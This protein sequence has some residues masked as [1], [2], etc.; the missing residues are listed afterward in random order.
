[1]PNVHIG[2]E[3]FEARLSNRSAQN[4]TDASGNSRTLSEREKIGSINLCAESLAKDTYKNILYCFLIYSFMLSS[5]NSKPVDLRHEFGEV[6]AEYDKESKDTVYYIAYA[7]TILNDTIRSLYKEYRCLEFDSLSDTIHGADLFT[8][9][10]SDN[11]DNA[12]NCGDIVKA[13]RWRN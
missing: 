12:F 1:M 5:C 2:L 13:T 9:E 6:Y 4:A 11:Y 8:E 3:E 10:H 7:D